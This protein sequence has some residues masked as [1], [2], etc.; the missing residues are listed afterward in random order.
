MN[1]IYHILTIIAAMKLTIKM[2]KTR[3]AKPA[4]LPK[5]LT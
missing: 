1:P 2:N 4:T 5:T 3:F